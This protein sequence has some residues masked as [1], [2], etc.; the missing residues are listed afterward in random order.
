M[1]K[2]RFHLIND[3]VSEAVAVED[4]PDDLAA[5]RHASYLGVELFAKHPDV[6]RKDQW[7]VRATDATGVVVNDAPVVE[8]ELHHTN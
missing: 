6:Y 7:R 5:Q 8:G 1:A 4:L 2:Y 3:N